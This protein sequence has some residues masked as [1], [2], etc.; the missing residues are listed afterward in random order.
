MNSQTQT[1]EHGRL[2]GQSYSSRFFR[3]VSATP[4]AIQNISRRHHSTLRTCTVS[5]RTLRLPDICGT[6]VQNGL[7]STRHMVCSTRGRFGTRVG[8]SAWCAR[9]GRMPRIAAPPVFTPFQKENTRV[10]VSTVCAIRF[11]SFPMEWICREQLRVESSPFEPV[12]QGRKVLLY[13]GRIHSKKGLANLIRAWK[14]TPNSQSSRLNSWILAIAGWDQGGHEEELKRL[15]SEL[16]ISF[17]EVKGQKLQGGDQP[18]ARHSRSGA[19]AKSENRATAVSQLSTPEIF[20]SDTI[21]SQRSPS[22]LFLGP[23]FGEE[24]ASAYRNADAFVL[25]SLSEGLPMAILEAWAH[26]KPVLMTPECNLPEGFA[27]GAALRIGSEAADIG[28]G[29]TQLFGM[30]DSDRKQMG[31]RGRSLVAEKFSWPRIGEQMRAVY[32][33]VLGGGPPPDTVRLN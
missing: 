29:L 20:A 2:C 26:A 21:N 25:P 9:S 4:S 28:T 27:A 1:S 31:T 14:A 12:A 33:W 6:G 10:C 8:K 5:G 13:L 16:G 7:S 23:R 15:A 11:A 17:V 18:A 32:E 19:G 22:L 24:K 3:A 30:A